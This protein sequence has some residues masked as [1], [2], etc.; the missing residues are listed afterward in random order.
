MDGA[1]AVCQVEID[2]SEFTPDAYFSNFH[3]WAFGPK[4]AAFLYISDRYLDVR[5][6]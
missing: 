3:K 4:S 6:Y 2:L 1:H 5:H